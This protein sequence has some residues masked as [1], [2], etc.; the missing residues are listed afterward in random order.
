MA[1]P[2][3]P[4]LPSIDDEL[5][6]PRKRLDL[7]AIKPRADMEDA[8]VEENSQKMGSEWGASTSLK[9]AKSDGEPPTPRSPVSSLRIE[10]PDY[11]DRALARAAVDQRVTKQ[12]LVLKALK[13][14]G[15]QI[16]DADFVADRRKTRQRKA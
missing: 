6:T 8:A 1:S 4:P 5:T 14:A 13:E 15:Y 10:V 9:T 3:K 16:E 2:G 12:Y 11:L 7:K